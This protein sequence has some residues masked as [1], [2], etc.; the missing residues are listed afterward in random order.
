MLSNA[1]SVILAHNHPSGNPVP[2]QQDVNLTKRLKDAGDLVGI[3]VLDHIVV[4][5]DGCTSLAEEG[6]LTGYSAPPALAKREK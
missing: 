2:S 4:T 1:K 5:A 3:P 6:H